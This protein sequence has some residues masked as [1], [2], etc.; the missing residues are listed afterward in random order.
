MSSH[1]QTQL[2]AMREIEAGKLELE[3]LDF[4][5][6]ELLDDFSA[7]LAYRAQD[8]GPEFVCAAD[9]D[10]P[11][12]L[13]GDPNR[14]RQILLNHAGNALKFTPRGQVSVTLALAEPPASAEGSLLLACRV[15]D[16][17]IG[18]PADKRERLFQSFSQVD[19]STTR[20]YGGTGLGIAISRQLVEL[21]GGAIGVES[22]EGQGSTFWFTARFSALPSHPAAATPALGDQRVLI[23]DDHADNREILNRRLASMGLRP[24]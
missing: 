20:E 14:L 1:V 23:V 19:A 17:G 10:V 18:I 3:S 9:P 15:R 7:T 6:D 4:D 2:A 8:Q 16:T 22:V 21:I 5:L 12:R 13:R 11:T 24:S